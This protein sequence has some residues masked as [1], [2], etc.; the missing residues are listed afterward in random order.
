MDSTV[1]IVTF[2]AFKKVYF[3]N[4]FTYIFILIIIAPY[5]ISSR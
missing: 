1:Y 4:L 3:E 2:K 5:R